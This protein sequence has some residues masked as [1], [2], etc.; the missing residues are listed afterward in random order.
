MFENEIKNHRKLILTP[1]YC[2]K[3]TFIVSIYSLSHFFINIWCNFVL[4]GLDLK[5]YTFEKDN[6]ADLAHF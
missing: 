1:Y 6:F 5:I 4:L 2:L 3:L